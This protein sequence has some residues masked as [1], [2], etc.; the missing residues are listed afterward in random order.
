MPKLADGRRRKTQM[1]TAPLA[2]SLAQA[3]AVIGVSVRFFEGLPIG[4]LRIGRRAL[5]PMAELQK[6][7]A[8]NTEPPEAA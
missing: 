3:A 1:P 6:Y 8:R 4:R 7:V 5:V 2:L